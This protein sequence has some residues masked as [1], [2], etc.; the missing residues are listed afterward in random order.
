M[1]SITEV[2]IGDFDPKAL[3]FKHILC[4]HVGGSEKMD[5]ESDPTDLYLGSVGIVYPEF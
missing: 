3:V 4:L 1:A 5:A 2:R